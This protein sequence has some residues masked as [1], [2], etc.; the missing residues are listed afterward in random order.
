MKGRDQSLTM[1]NT[2]IVALVLGCTVAGAAGGWLID[3][4]T[5]KTNPR[6]LGT[7]FRIA[8]RDPR[9]TGTA[10]TRTPSRDRRDPSGTP[11]PTSFG[12]QT[13]VI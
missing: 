12:P 9:S 8:A 1:M 3:R 5:I 10:A 2:K 13:W 7:D 6:A 11:R 4:A